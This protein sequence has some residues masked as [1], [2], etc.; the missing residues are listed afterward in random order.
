MTHDGNMGNIENGCAAALASGARACDLALVRLCRLQLVAAGGL[1]RP[2]KQ[3]GTPPSCYNAEVHLKRHLCASMPDAL[4]GQRKD[5][6]GAAL[7]ASAA[8]LQQ[9]PLDDAHVEAQLYHAKAA[10]KAAAAQ[11]PASERLREAGEEARSRLPHRTRQ[12]GQVQI[13]R[14][15]GIHQALKHDTVEGSLPALVTRAMRS[16]LVGRGYDCRAAAKQ[17]RLVHLDPL[18]QQQCPC[19]ACG[20]LQLSLDRRAHRQPAHLQ[21]QQRWKWR[22]GWGDRLPTQPRPADAMDEGQIFLARDVH[23]QADAVAAVVAEAAQHSGRICER[24]ACL[25]RHAAFSQ[26]HAVRD[27][28]EIASHMR[29]AACAR[30]LAVWA[31]LR[32][33][34][35]VGG[36]G[37]TGYGRAGGS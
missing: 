32:A 34:A 27:E 37:S 21:H 4:H 10:R 3:L 36:G 18:S 26:H 6:R 12:M 13:S 15:C 7:T 25:W 17:D 35:A 29:H 23:D 5:C 1:Q 14:M 24:Q 33:R 22:A 11:P 8:A 30:H 19:L 2:N 31:D 20:C 28:A 9:C 16:G